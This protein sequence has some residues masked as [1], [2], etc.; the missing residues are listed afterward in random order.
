MQWT[1]LESVL[2]IQ[3]ILHF[4]ENLIVF[5]VHCNLR[6]ITLHA[7]LLVFFFYATSSIVTNNYISGYKT[8]FDLFNFDSMN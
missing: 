8:Q 4:M 5:K 6:S 7:T 3:L 1:Y 2:R